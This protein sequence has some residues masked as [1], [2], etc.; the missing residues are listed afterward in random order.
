MGYESRLYVVNKWENSMK[1]PIIIEDVDYG[2]RVWSEIIAM[3]NVSKYPE[4]SNFMRKQP[5]TD[6]YIYADDGN[7]HIVSDRYGDVMTEC[8]VEELLE[9]IQREVDKG[10][11]YRRLMPLYSLL[12]GFDPKQ[13][14]NLRVLHF[15]Y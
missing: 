9:V 3:M 2:E 1:L 14:S 10:E 5:I 7:T 11:D 6:S 4:I 12:K 15:G 8:S 13:W